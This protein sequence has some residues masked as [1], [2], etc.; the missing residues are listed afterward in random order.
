MVIK[1]K[2]KGTICVTAHPEGLVKKVQNDIEF[3][4]ALPRLA[5][6]PRSVLVIGASRGYGL[7]ARVVAAFSGRSTTIGVSS[8]SKPKKGQVGRCSYYNNW[9]FRK[10]AKDQGVPAYDLVGDAFSYETKARTVQLLREE[11]IGPVDL[12]VYSLGTSRRTDPDTNEVYRS[13][14]KPIGS[15]YSSK[16]LDTDSKE[17]LEGSLEAA[18]DDEIRNTVKVMGGEDWE[19]WL[20]ALQSEDLLSHGCQTVAFDYLGPETMDRIYRGGTIG[21]AKVDLRRAQATIDHKLRR[22]GGHGRIAALKAVVTQSSAAIP[23]VNLYM[24]LLYKHMKELGTH[25]NAMQQISRLFS[26]HLYSNIGAN[27][28]TKGM[29]RLD[30]YETV[31]HVQKRIQADWNK[32]ETS[33]IDQYFDFESYCGEFRKLFGFD[34]PGIDYQQPTDLS[35]YL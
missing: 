20:N 31:P 10:F 1:P 8:Q 7:A 5:N 2:I 3:A 6:A 33:N 29:F 30:N 16:Y 9:A 22:I 34:V 17:I 26:D 25:E 19:L 14:L 32:I 35:R 15:A 18:S 28:S 4:L 23:G 24:A 13:T 11:G 21:R 27:C 12:V